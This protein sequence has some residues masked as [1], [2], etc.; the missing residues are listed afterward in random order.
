MDSLSLFLNNPCWHILFFLLQTDIRDTFS[1]LFAQIISV[2][3]ASTEEEQALRSMKDQPTQ[4]SQKKRILTKKFP[5]I[6]G[7]KALFRSFCILVTKD[8]PPPPPNNKKK[9]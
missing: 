6:L 8:N 9:N 2:Y 4:G 1:V 3:N 5:K 7:L